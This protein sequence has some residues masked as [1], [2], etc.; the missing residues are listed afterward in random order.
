MTTV[1]I[2]VAAMRFCTL[3]PS[4]G[5]GPNGVSFPRLEFGLRSVIRG[6]FERDTH[7]HT[8]SHLQ[9]QINI[10]H[11]FGAS[12]LD[13]KTTEERPFSASSGF[14]GTSA[15]PGRR[16]VRSVRRS[17]VLGISGHGEGDQH[18]ARKDR[19]GP[20]LWPDGWRVRTLR[21]RGSQ[22]RYE[23]SKA[24]TNYRLLVGGIG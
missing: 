5:F 3:S 16:S 6:E 12:I 20:N 11:G 24:A 2:T 18:D 15:R 1:A 13:P 21:A 8:H 17:L 4:K 9:F 22:H 10:S 7:T 23:R 14:A 19:Q